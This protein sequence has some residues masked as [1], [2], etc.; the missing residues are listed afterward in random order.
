MPQ[1]MTSTRSPGLAGRR[2]AARVARAAGLDEDG[3][4]VGDVIGD[5]E[6]AAGQG[7][8]L[9]APAAAD[10]AVLADRVVHRFAAICVPFSALAAGRLAAADQAVAAAAI[11]D[12]TIANL[13]LRHLGPRLHDLAHD[14][15]A[16]VDAVSAAG[17]GRRGDA[18]VALRPDEVEVGAA[19]AR[20]AVADLHVARPR[21]AWRRDIHLLEGGQRAEKHVLGEARQGSC[22]QH[23]LWLDIDVQRFM[24][25]P[26]PA[27]SGTRRCPVVPRLAE[28]NIALAKKSVKSQVGQS[29]EA[30]FH[31]DRLTANLRQCYKCA[32]AHNAVVLSAVW[33]RRP[34]RPRGGTW[35]ESLEG[36][37][38]LASPKS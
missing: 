1:P 10:G 14:L 12:H 2:R 29:R 25:P 20:Q 4:L 9:L 32:N 11:L 35:R 7:H 16:H 3:L 27:T 15:V 37:G 36:R 17:Q 6:Q 23:A 30:R 38:P 21:Q 28:E 26:F 5:L 13:E 8:P 31:S 22:C 33:P 24:R 34:P 18:Q 19:D